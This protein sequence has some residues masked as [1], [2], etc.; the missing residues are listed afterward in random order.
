M[1]DNDKDLI[2]YNDYENVS[3]YKNRCVFDIKIHSPA[4]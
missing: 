2:I 1:P 3:I 4:M